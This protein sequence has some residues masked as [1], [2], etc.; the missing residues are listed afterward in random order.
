MRERPGQCATR[1]R[2]DGGSAKGGRGPIDRQPTP[3]RFLK[4]WAERGASQTGKGQRKSE[5]FP[6]CAEPEEA[7]A[8]RFRMANEELRKSFRFVNRVVIHKKIVHDS[9]QVLRLL[10]PF[11]GFSPSTEKR[12]SGSTL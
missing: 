5:R 6:G 2:R 12:T 10:P 11:S 1:A 9:F 4:S 3:C 8:R 7:D